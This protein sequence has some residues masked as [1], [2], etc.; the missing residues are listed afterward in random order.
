MSVEEI[1]SGHVNVEY[2]KDDKDG[3]YTVWCKLCRATITSIGMTERSF[4]A[5]SRAFV[6]KHENCS[7]G[8]SLSTPLL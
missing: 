5:N 3:T 4:D 7:P 6:R 2:M 8:F 1:L